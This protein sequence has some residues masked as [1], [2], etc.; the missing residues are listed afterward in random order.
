MLITHETQPYFNDG[1]LSDI[2]Q[3]KAS[4]TINRVVARYERTPH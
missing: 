3:L 4:D 1:K 2:I